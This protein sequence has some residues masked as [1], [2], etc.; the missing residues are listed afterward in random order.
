MPRSPGVMPRKKRRRRRTQRKKTRRATPMKTAVRRAALVVT[1]CAV[2]HVRGSII[3]NAMCRRCAVLPGRQAADG[4]LLKLHG[5]MWVYR[6]SISLHCVYYRLAQ[7]YI[8]GQGCRLSHCALLCDPTA[9]LG[10]SK[11]GSLCCICSNSS[12]WR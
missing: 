12:V 6:L 9:A 7:F 11:L 1:C 10:C 8:V 2:T 3:W 4:W 5:T